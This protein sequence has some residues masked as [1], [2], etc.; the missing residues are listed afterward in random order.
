MVAAKSRCGNCRSRQKQGH[1]REQ[2]CSFKRSQESETCGAVLDGASRR[3]LI[4]RQ[5]CE[6][7]EDQH[8]VQDDV[9]IR[10]GV[11][12]MQS[13]RPLEFFHHLACRVVDIGSSESTYRF[14]EY[15]LKYDRL[16]LTQPL[17]TLLVFCWILQGNK[18]VLGS[19]AEYSP[20]TSPCQ[21]PKHKQSQATAALCSYS[22]LSTLPP[23]LIRP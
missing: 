2:H 15:N 8:E 5:R 19:L 7:K 3:C 22:L 11:H 16:I 10:C 20:H 9:V 13:F 23:N 12:P 18:S 17:D 1:G 21:P 4:A 6:S 14:L